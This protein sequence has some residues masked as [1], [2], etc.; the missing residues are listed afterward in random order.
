MRDPSFPSGKFDV[1]NRYHLLVSISTSIY[2]YEYTYLRVYISTSIYIYEYIYLRVSPDIYHDLAL[3]ID[4]AHCGLAG[5]DDAGG[6]GPDD[7]Q[8]HLGWS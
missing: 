2:I 3:H 5:A 6:R 7:C 8:G 4:R 1:S